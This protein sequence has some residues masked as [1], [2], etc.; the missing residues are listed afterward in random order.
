MLKFQQYLNAR[1]IRSLQHG[2]TVFGL[3]GS[4]TKIAT[5]VITTKHHLSVHVIFA[6]DADGQVRKLVVVPRSQKT[7]LVE[8]LQPFPTSTRVLTMKLLKEEVSVTPV[9]ARNEALAVQ[10]CN[11]L[12]CS[13]TVGNRRFT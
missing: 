7:C 5:D 3:S 12:S 13:V 8:L 1:A 4:L 10:F 11:H 9:L 6:S 2:V